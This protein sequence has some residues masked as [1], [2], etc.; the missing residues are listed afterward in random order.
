[1]SERSTLID[2]L[3]R[4]RDFRASYIWAKL[5]VLVPSQLR[6]LRLR[7]GLTQPAL[8]T[9]A[10]MLQSR[11][12]AMETPG[13]TNFNLETLV[14]MAATFRVGLIVKFVP[15]SEMLRWDNCH[16][17]DTFDV[18]PLDRDIEFINPD[19][20]SV[21]NAVVVAPVGT[22]LGNKG[23]QMML[24]IPTVANF[25]EGT[26]HHLQPQAARGGLPNGRKQAAA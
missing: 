2:K 24:P 19:A 18:V 10:G 11:I 17:Q 23:N 3:I 26:S 1:M 7:K 12:S 21:R 25:L 15:F 13:K 6:A 14:R 9:E 20:G 5:D 22:V 4:E 8:A 16:S